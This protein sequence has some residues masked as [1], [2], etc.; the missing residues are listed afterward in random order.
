M[1]VLS[2]RD[3]LARVAALSAA[4]VMP[5][6]IARALTLPASTR[7]G[8]LQDVEHFIIVMQEN[9][10]FDHYFGTLRGVRGFDDPRPL[11][12]RNGNPVWRQPAGDGTE[13]MP[14]AMDATTTRAPM[15]ASLDHS[16][17]GGHG[18]DPKRWQ[19]YDS[20]V[21]YKSEM[22]MGH[23]S[24]ADIPYY[25]ALADAFTVCDGYYCSL[26]GPTNPNRM[27][28]F[29]GTSG[30][31]VGN[32]GA[33]SID[34]ADDGNWT[35]DMSRDKPGFVGMEWTTYAERLQAAGITWQVYQEL[36]N[37]GDNPL[38]SFAKFR[39]MDTSGE[40]YQRG[41]AVVA[42][43]TPE[44]ARQS[45]AQ[46]L[47]DAFAADVQ[48]GTLPQVSWIVA[49]YAYSEHPEATPAYGE[50]LVSRLIDALTANPEVWGRSC[51]IINY[52]ENDGFFDHMPAPLPALDATMGVS[53]VDVRGES[54][55]GVPVGLGVRVPMTV[56]SPWT[57]GGWVNSQVFDHTSVLRLLEQR[58]GVVEP[59]ITPWRRA[60]TGDLSTVFDFRTPDDSALEALPSTTD[61]L[62]RMAA[63]AKLPLPVVPARQ[64]QP[65]QEPG[66]RPA[67]ALPYALQVHAHHGADGLRLTLVNAGDAA[68]VFNVY[69]Y[70]SD[71]GPWY[72]TVMP[73]SE[74][75]DAPHGLPAGNYSLAVHGP[76]GFLREFEGATAASEPVPDVI[77]SAS[78]GQLL[79]VLD[80]PGTQA[81]TLEVRA[82]DYGDPTPRRVVLAAGQTERLGFDLAAS[83]HW[84][85]LQV[86]LSGTPFRRRLAGHLET[87]R[88]SRSDPAIGRSAKV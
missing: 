11:K 86:E 45:T 21:P 82:L 46:H 59:N 81:R 32:F 48:A 26:H 24:R 58:F 20:W 55:N 57:R 67:R 62:A 80:N 69:A 28:F 14:F 60:V 2:R 13:R 18:Q 3:F 27:Y 12:L 30:M 36:D 33:Q 38:S 15:I 71:A 44:N 4:G 6:S 17:K 10:S 73:H 66:Q 42:G 72:Y 39:G 51:V 85:D 34:N 53:Q 19:A 78:G 31:A 74:V 88:P 7:S 9:R 1:P 25:H 68:A 61:Y 77:A 87:G 40:L 65:T 16:W 54:Y 83:D 41:R 64:V 47:V 22:T 23:F 29:S 49:P 37:F 8:T 43:S 70:G 35:S 76:N 56:V 5:A 63:S 75:I 52:D 79:L 84:Y 50:S